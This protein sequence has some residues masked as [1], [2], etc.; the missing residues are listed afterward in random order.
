M[1]KFRAHRRAMD[2]FSGMVGV[3]AC[4][5]AMA[6][7]KAAVQAKLSRALHEAVV[8]AV[9]LLVA[10]GPLLGVSNNVDANE[11]AD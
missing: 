8:K 9:L 7:A 11:L 3:K 10:E 1:G 5:R 6:K 4:R 2:R